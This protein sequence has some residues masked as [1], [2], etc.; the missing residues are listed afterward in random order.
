MASPTQLRVG[1]VG[2]G[3][4]GGILAQTIARGDSIRVTACADLDQS[5]AKRVAKIVDCAAIFDSVD[6]M[7]AQA[8]LDAVIVATSHDAL[9]KC[10]LAAIRAGKHVLGEKPIGIDEAQATQ[11][12]DAAATMKVIFMTG[13]S[14]RYFPALQKIRE[15]LQA[16]A[17]GEIQSVMGAIGVGPMNKGWKA[18]PETGGGPMLYVGSHLVD[19]MLWY[20][21]DDPVKAYADI[22]CRADTRADETTAFQIKFAKGATAQGMVTQTASTFFNHLDILGRQGRISLRSLGFDYSVQMQSNILPAY[23][24]AATIHWPQADDLRIQMHLP[25]LAEFAKAI[26]NLSQPTCTVRDGRRVLHVL[27]AFKESARVGRPIKI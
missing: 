9:C 6:A 26:Q 2:C 14:F 10:A 4:Q 21:A 3:N 23:S 27:D 13:Y 8:E 19:E 5:A 25:Q 18:T 22:R 7:L 11:L 15:L 24:Q 1:I 16:N 17:I 20:I 12:E